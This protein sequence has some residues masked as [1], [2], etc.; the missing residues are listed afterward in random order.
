MM[1]NSAYT[2]SILKITKA[3]IV[4]GFGADKVLLWTDLPSTMPKVTTQN[5]CLSFDTEIDTGAD[6]V[7]RHFGIEPEIIQR[8]RP[9][10]NFRG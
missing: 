3:T 8:E 6:Y 9:R 1:I 4:L 10:S 7:R 5:M 2:V